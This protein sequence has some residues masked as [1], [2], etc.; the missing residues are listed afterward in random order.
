MES[1]RKFG[2][3]EYYDQIYSRDWGKTE[4]DIIYKIY[5]PK[6]NVFFIR[7]LY[8]IDDGQW[9]LTHFDINTK[10][11]LALPRK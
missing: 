2:K 7:Y 3:S 8:H 11:N 6:G 9:R 1:V 10:Q 5:F 4:K